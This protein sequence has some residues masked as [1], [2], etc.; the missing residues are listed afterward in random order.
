MKY[1][2]IIRIFV[3]LRIDLNS[4][5]INNAI[6]E[7]VKCG[8]VFL[9][10]NISKASGDN[11]GDNI[12]SK[13]VM[14]G[15]LT[16]QY[17]A[18]KNRNSDYYGLCHYRRYLSFADEILKL[19]H[20]NMCRET[21][22]TGNA[23]KRHHLDDGKRIYD[24]V[25]S[26]DLVFLMGADVKKIYVRGGFPRNVRQLWEAHHNLFIDKK[27]LDILLERIRVL[28]P[29]YYKSAL[30]YFE[31]DI[32]YGFNCYVMRKEFF[33][34]LCEFQYPILF[35]LESQILS[36]N[37]GGMM[38]RLPGYLGEIMYGIFIYHLI[39]KENVRYKELPVVF[40]LTTEKVSGPI[41]YACRWIIENGKS[42][43]GERSLKVFPRGSKRREFLKRLIK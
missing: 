5:Q 13:R 15:E 31:S 7:P 22:I 35:E 20:F 12:S 27:Y 38:E 2:Y 6:Y 37:Y 10:N 3:S 9:N 40:F 25:T 28:K 43:I 8:A 1:V 19:D 32:H 26:N 16:V 24:V 17:W 18:W 14:Y 21:A 30:E 36:E 23:I 4:I 34:R 39:H 41:D 42:F 11:I 29:E 33:F